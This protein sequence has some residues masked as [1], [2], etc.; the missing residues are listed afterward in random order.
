L[1]QLCDGIE[2]DHLVPQSIKKASQH[3]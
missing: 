3:C 2:R 1:G